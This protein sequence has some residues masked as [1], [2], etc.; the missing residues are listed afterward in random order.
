MLT[1]VDPASEALA[2]SI[3][4][5]GRVDLPFIGGASWKAG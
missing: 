1:H 4:E 5:R 2:V 3:G